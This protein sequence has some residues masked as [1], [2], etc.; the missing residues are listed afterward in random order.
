MMNYCEGCETYL[1]KKGYS[2]CSFHKDNQDGSCPCSQCIVKMMCQI[3]CDPYE[4]WVAD[5]EAN[6]PGLKSFPKD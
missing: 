4:D 1:N 5:V 2:D 6:E 3:P